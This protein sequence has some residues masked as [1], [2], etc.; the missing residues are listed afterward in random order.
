MSIELDNA[1]IRERAVQGENMTL[2]EHYDTVPVTGATDYKQFS[3][4]PKVGATLVAINGVESRLRSLLQGTIFA[5][6]R[7][8]EIVKSH[9]A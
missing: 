3:A 7:L 4:Y 8:L 5:P 6:D 9:E 1:F 2:Q